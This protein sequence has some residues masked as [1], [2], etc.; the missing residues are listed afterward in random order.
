M[1]QFEK[2]AGPAF[3]YGK[4][5]LNRPTLEAKRKAWRAALEWIKYIV[6]HENDGPSNPKSLIQCIDEELE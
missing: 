4:D 6:V 1:E 5:P 2:W 3:Y